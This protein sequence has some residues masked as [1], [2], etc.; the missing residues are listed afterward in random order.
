VTVCF[1]ATNVFRTRARRHR[2][3]GAMSGSNDTPEAGAGKFGAR[4]HQAHSRSPDPLGRD[5]DAVAALDAIVN[6]DRVYGSRDPIGAL[7]HIISGR[8]GG[9]APSVPPGHCCVEG[10]PRLAWIDLRPGKE[11]CCRTCEGTKGKHHGP[12][13]DAKHLWLHGKGGGKGGDAKGKSSPLPS[14]LPPPP[15]PPPPPTAAPPPLPPPTA[16]PPPR[17]PPL[18]RW[19]CCV[20]GCRRL[21][22]TDEKLYEPCCRTCEETGGKIHGRACIEKHAWLGVDFNGGGSSSGKRHPADG[23]GSSSG[24]RPKNQRM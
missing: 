15:P 22:W 9:K 10:C 17:P 7:E 2:L 16:A 4:G 23:G 13:C 20:K 14:L 1:V 11:P 6:S 3:Y 8:S 21:A 5:G 19:Q 18:P 24:K 12:V